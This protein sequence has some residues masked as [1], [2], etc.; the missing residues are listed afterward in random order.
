MNRD[1]GEGEFGVSVFKNTDVEKDE[2]EIEWEAQVA[3]RPWQDVD[4]HVIDKIG[5]SGCRAAEP[6]CCPYRPY[7]FPPVGSKFSIDFAGHCC[8]SLFF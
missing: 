8:T 5:L 1:A 2:I 4:K 3:P 7:R 6:Q